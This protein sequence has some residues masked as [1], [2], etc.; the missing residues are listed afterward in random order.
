MLGG[1]EVGNENKCNKQ[2]I[3]ET[4]RDTPL[5]FKRT[6]INEHEKIP[7]RN[8]TQTNKQQQEQKQITKHNKQNNEYLAIQNPTLSGNAFFCVCVTRL[9]DNNSK[10]SS[11]ITFADEF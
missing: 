4:R 10:N 8:P 5:H 11:H 1:R 6:K 2:R 9:Y 3:D 7:P